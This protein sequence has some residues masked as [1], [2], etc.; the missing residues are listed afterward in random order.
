MN[1]ASLAE[2][3]A[4]S[5]SRNPW[6][7]FVLEAHAENGAERLLQEGFEQN[8][9]E[10]TEDIY[11]HHLAGE[12]EFMVDHLDK[13]FWSFHTTMPIADAMRCLRNAVGSR[14]DLDWM[15][16]PSAH[17]SNIWSGASLQWLAADYHARKLSPSEDPLNDLQVQLR[18]RGHQADEVLRVIAERYET[19]VPQDE[20]GIS[21]TDTQL[22]W[23]NER[24]NYRGRFMANGDDFNFHQSIV[25]RVIGRYRDFVEAVERRL[26]LWTELPDGGARLS[27]VPIVIKFSRPIPDVGLFAES[28][29]SSRE[30]YR[31]WGLYDMVGDDM[32][33]VE[34]VDLHVGQPLRFD[35]TANWLR[36]Y[37]FEG[38]CGNSIARLAANLQRHFDGGLSIVDDELEGLL[39]PRP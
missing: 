7:T 33:E 20:V 12:V 6:K 32:A 3:Y 8:C 11:L 21:A 31:L 24:I 17:L 36:V 34:A 15:W 1:R 38:G 28:L 25:R 9:V 5:P 29:F 39:K 4:S 13:R 35:I 22:G 37:L 30:P 16:L 14:S 27:G 10:R 2:Q 19:S 18:V 26:L 23:V